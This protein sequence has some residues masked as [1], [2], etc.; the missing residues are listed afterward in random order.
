[1]PPRCGSLKQCHGDDLSRQWYPST[2]TRTHHAVDVAECA[3][4]P[5]HTSS[6][7]NEALVLAFPGQGSLAPG[8][9]DAW[10]AHAAF[11]AVDSV[12]Q[13]AGVDVVRLLTKADEDELVS[14][15][16]AQ[17]ATFAL[18]LCVLDA[19]GLAARARVVL[20]HSLGEYTALVAAGHRVAAPTARAS[21]TA[22]GA[23]MRDAADSPPGGLVAL[24][25]GG[26]EE[27]EAACAAIDGLYLANLNGP[28]Q[29]VVG[30]ELATLEALVARAQGARLSPGDPAQ[31]RWRLPH[32]AHGTCR[33]GA[34]ADP[35]ARRRSERGHAIVLANVDGAPHE[36]PADWP[37]LLLRQL[38]EPVRLRARASARFPR[39]PSSSSAAP[40]SVLKGLIARI[41]ED[42]DVRSDQHARRPRRARGASSDRPR[43]VVVT[44]ASRGIGLAIARLVHRRR[45]PGRRALVSGTEV[46]GR[47]AQRSR[48]TSPTARPGG[49]G[50]QRGRGRARRR[51]TCSS[52]T[53]ASRST[54][55]RCG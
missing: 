53:P 22:R 9:G 31:G 7:P 38:T 55:S 25:G 51:A 32:A 49:R 52:R 20:G 44:G 27:A 46:A 4:R 42:L 43:V 16:N 37:A 13:D 41:R 12:A 35:R 18:S 3:R 50:V 14:T 39:A 21:S 29:I 54:S 2:V 5:C 26:I 11:A 36:D 1:M 48:A 17:I 40:G 19:T 33:A 10:A 28:G 34:R 45:R 47:G 30:G 23:A 15:E 24:L 8:A 6:V